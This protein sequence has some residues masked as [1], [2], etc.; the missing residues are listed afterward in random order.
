MIEERSSDGATNLLTK[1]ACELGR[2]RKQGRPAAQACILE[3]QLALT[4]RMWPDILSCMQWCK[5]PRPPSVP[6]FSREETAVPAISIQRRLPS[7]GL[8]FQFLDSCP[9]RNASLSPLRSFHNLLNLYCE[10]GTP[11]SNG[12]YVFPATEE[13][14]SLCTSLRLRGRWSAVR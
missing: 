13:L 4:A 2:R 1:G 5:P 10:E 11:D 9:S 8:P 3:V 6:R 14:F 12:F 7:T